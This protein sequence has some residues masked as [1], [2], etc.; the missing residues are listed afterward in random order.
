MIQQLINPTLNISQR[1]R[2]VKTILALSLIT[3]ICF[4]LNWWL[5]A[6]YYPKMALYDFSF[7]EIADY[8]L[9]GVLS[10]SLIGVFLYRSPKF[11]VF[12]ST[13]CLLF[14]VFTDTAKGQYWLF[15][16]IGILLLLCGH[17]WRIDNPRRYSSVFTAIKILVCL[18]YV[19]SAIQF[20]QTSVNGNVWLQFIAPLEKICTPEQHKYILGIRYAVPFIELFVVVSLFVNRIKM[21]AIVIGICLH[22]FSFCLLLAETPY[23]NA[24]VLMWNICMIF[25]LYF[26]FAGKTAEQKIY[27]VSF[28]LYG[29]LVLLL[30]AFGGL[31]KQDLF[32]ENKI[33]LMQSNNNEQ[34]IY[35]KQNEKNRLPLYVQYFTT[36]NTDNIY[37]QL[38]VTKW[39]ANETKTHPVLNN[40]QLLNVCDA[41][42][43]YC[44]ANA[45]IVIS[46]QEQ[47]NNEI[48]ANTYH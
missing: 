40:K 41:L 7:N 28:N 3:S 31:I 8:V 2:I 27:A 13:L 39:C 44:G 17:N 47:K 24:G 12:L 11:F 6:V 9:L 1:L 23:A 25:L 46:I 18:M 45:D 30:I 34:F 37:A 32:P 48:A 26:L 42:K 36:N 20:L 21:A 4:T 43:V 35:I 14:A 38:S 15:F 33:D 22:L 10:I 5:P 29:T 19:L 16:Y